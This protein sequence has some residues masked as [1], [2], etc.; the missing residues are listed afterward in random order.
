MIALLPY[1][2]TFLAFGNLVI[3]LWALKTFLT[4][5]QTTLETK[6]EE[7]KK[8]VDEH[9]VKIKEI[10][11]SLHLGNDKFKDQKDTNELMIRSI[12]ALVAFEIDYCYKEGKQLSEEL[13]EIHDDLQRYLARK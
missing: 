6:H 2:Q 10:D 9:D 8:R 5:P 1:L 7:L 3:M 13:K 4:K 11:E 12:F